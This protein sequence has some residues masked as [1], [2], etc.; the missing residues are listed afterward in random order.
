[1]SLICNSGDGFRQH[2]KALYYYS[3]YLK[4]AISNIINNHILVLPEFDFS[5]GE[6]S[7][8]LGAFHYYSIGDIFTFLSFLIPN[9]YLHLYYDGTIFV[10][11]FIAGITFICLCNYF[12][13]KEDP[14]LIGSVIY[15][16]T[17]FSLL[18][19]CGHIFFL[20]VLI[21]LP[22]I[23]IGVE[24]ILKDES[25]KVMILGVTFCSLSN[26]YFFYV[27]ALTVVIYVVCRLALLE[28]PIKEKISYFLNI[29]ISAIIGTMISCVAFLPIAYM[30]LGSSRSFNPNVF[31]FLYPVD[32]YLRLYSSFYI[33]SVDGYFGGYSTLGILSV[34]YI[35]ERKDKKIL[36]YFLAI[37]L[38]ACIF[39]FFGQLFN[40]MLYPSDRWMFSISLLMAYCATLLLENLNEIA[41][42]PKKYFLISV[43]YSISTI[44]ID[45]VRWQIHTL[46][47]ICVLA[48]LLGIKFINKKYWRLYIGGI[49]LVMVLFNILYY[50][51]PLWWDYSRKGTPISLASNVYSNE[52]EYI[53]KIED[54]SFWRYAG[55]NLETN[56]SILTNH[57]QSQ[58]YWSVANRNVIEF[59]KDMGLS[60]HNDHH[61]DSYD[62]RLS[63]LSLSSAKYFA[64]KNDEEVMIPYGY[65]FYKSDGDYLVYSSTNSLPLIYGYSHFI[66]EDSYEKLSILEKQRIMLESAI[67]EENL[68]Q[69][70]MVGDSKKVIPVDFE[71][72]TSEGISLLN[73]KIVSGDGE[74]FIDISFFASNLSEYY[75][76]IL[77][78][79]SSL[80]ADIDIKIGDINKAIQFKDKTHTRYAG[81]HDFLINL[82]VYENESVEI[83]INIPKGEFTYDLLEIES[84]DIASQINDINKLNSI[85]IDDLKIDNDKVTS[86]VLLDEN[87]LVCLSIPYS[88]G[89]IGM[90]DG[91]EADIIR[92]NKQY[93]GFMLEKGAHT[94]ELTYRTPLLK[95]GMYLSFLGVIL[96]IFVM[97]R[98]KKRRNQ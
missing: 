77:N 48:I 80:T 2:F 60:D 29:A 26:I 25:K 19:I 21:Y 35:C 88:N 82:G 40:V 92:I 10:R 28:E 20:N 74:Q 3:N 55:D 59:R 18:T 7:D 87:K 1:M 58:Y 63:L 50:Y 36:Q 27:V 72:K 37:I 53:D 47:F 75:L 71:I 52:A 62:D 96:F 61:Y 14:T 46:Y 69:S 90:V 85:T 8:V 44:I 45:S 98:E 81:R 24:K 30:M 93:M 6:G 57:S 17:N 33:G 38:I 91:K 11:L 67:I 64:V 51:S 84:I 4:T 94:I 54:D 97:L 49:T 68:S 39:P 22:L 56:S 15:L 83:K 79:D 41:L 42:N 9:K 32:T 89:W 13:R 73:N 12:G 31:S 65:D 5:I 16:F 95:E 78:L 23:I 66:S 34:I 76:C 43:L 70:L 86:N